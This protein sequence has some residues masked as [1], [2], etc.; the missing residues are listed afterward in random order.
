MWLSNL[1]EPLSILSGQITGR[2]SVPENGALMRTE[3][4]ETFAYSGSPLT[5]VWS[6]A[7]AAVAFSGHGHGHR[8]GRLPVLRREAQADPA[9]L[10]T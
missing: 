8:L 9:F 5:T 4:A 2:K 6:T 3:A 7:V 1:L 10:I